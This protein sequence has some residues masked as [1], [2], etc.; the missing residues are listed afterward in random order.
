MDERMR[1]IAA[2]LT[3]LYTM[4]ELC[5][6]SRISRKTGYKWWDRYLAEGAAGLEE[7][8]HAPHQAAHVTPEAIA[9]RIL[10]VRGAHPSWGPCKIIGF[11]H[12]QAA[13]IAWP[14]PSTAGEILK[15]A[16]LVEPRRPRR[17]AP[18]RLDA[19]RLLLLP[20]AARWP[21]CLSRGSERGKRHL[22][23]SRANG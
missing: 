10:A 4:T 8:S 6:A 18:P 7:R 17:R 1:F 15:R 21:S 2:R 23:S 22:T 3:G 13:G 19:L 11:L 5:E 12:N 9:E 14:A 20:Q 16:G